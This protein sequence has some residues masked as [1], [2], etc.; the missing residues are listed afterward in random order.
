[1]R[2]K[3]LPKLLL[4]IAGSEQAKA[5]GHSIIFEQAAIELQKLDAIEQYI[6]DCQHLNI[7][8]QGILFLLNDGNE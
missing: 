7:T 1:M 8:K 4:A 3:D 2:N 6:K 5:N